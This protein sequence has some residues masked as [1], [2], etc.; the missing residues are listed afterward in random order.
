MKRNRLSTLLSLLLIGASAMA[1]ITVSW[2]TIDK[3]YPVEVTAEI[4][5][6]KNP[7]LTAWKG[8]RV[9]MQLVVANPG[10]EQ[11]ISIIFD[12]LTDG[13]GNIISAANIKGGIVEPVIADT[14]TG[15]SRHAIDAHG[16]YPTADR[17]TMT[18]TAKIEEKAMRG[19]WMTLQVPRDIKSGT[20]KGKVTITAGEKKSVRQYKVKVL[21]SVLPEPKD[22]KFHL[23]LWQNPYAVARYHDVT[24]WS[25]EHFAVLRPYM[26]KLAA[27]GQ[28]AI[29]ATLINKPWNGQTLDPFGSMVTWIK[30]ADGRWIY[31]FTIFDRW[32]EFMYDCGISEEITCFS[33]IPWRLSFR[34]Y[35]QATDSHKEIKCAPGQKEYTEYWG[36]ML[37]AFR[38]HLVEKG[39]LDKTFISM[40]ERSMKQMQAAIKVIHDYAPGLKI[41]LAGYYHPEIEKDLWDYSV[42]NNGGKEFPKGVVERRRSEGKKST[43]YT[44]C[45]A[46]YPNVFTFTDPADCEYVALHSL[47]ID[48]DG[49]LR[50]AYNSWTAEPEKDSRFTSWPSGD[51]YIIYPGNTSSIRWERLVQGI[52]SFEKW[53]IMMNDAKSRNDKSMQNKLNK[54]LE[55]LDINKIANESERMTEEFR[56]GLNRLSASKKY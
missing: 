44:C 9:N 6:V 29:T 28:K 4:K 43:Y 30:L 16:T 2:G 41:S 53:H 48:V 39:W 23:D 55:I 17:I 33:M 32:V 10:A 15:C 22:W 36:G 27:A 52:E 5:P 45:S 7:S 31:D 8:E 42:N 21:E 47:K 13:K 19:L 25:E 3:R 54:L 46:E 34:Y 49:Y 20:Y 56:A 35:D 1:Q 24:P 37:K 38:A 18:E 11:E 12:D 14:F 40:D 51:T 26:E 50:W